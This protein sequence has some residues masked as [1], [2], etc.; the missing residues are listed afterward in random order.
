MAQKT[1]TKLLQYEHLTSITAELFDYYM[2]YKILLKR[3]HGIIK[4]RES[5]EKSDRHLEPNLETLIKTRALMRQEQAKIVAGV[6][7]PVTHMYPPRCA[8]SPS[9]TGSI[10]KPHR[11]TQEDARRGVRNR[12][13][14]FAQNHHRLGRQDYS[15]PR[16]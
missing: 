4:D 3:V 12:T 8:D 14:R 13:G 6:C 7:S 2:D 9:V 10:S 1:T 5:Y 16:V 11:V 15:E